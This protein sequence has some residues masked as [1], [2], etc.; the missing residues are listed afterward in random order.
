MFL[1]LIVSMMFM[2]A[3]SFAQSTPQAPASWIAFQQQENAKRSAFFKEMKADRDAFL[4]SNPEVKA[5][6]EQVRAAAKARFA[7]LRAARQK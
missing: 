6:L 5:Y 7:A 3:V 2:P 1:G 4:S